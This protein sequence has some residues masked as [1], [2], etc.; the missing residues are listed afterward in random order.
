VHGRTSQGKHKKSARR[1]LDEVK[2]FLAK[3]D[4]HLAEIA[5]ASGAASAAGGESSAKNDKAAAATPASGKKRKP[6]DGG[7]SK[8]SSK[9]KKK[10]AA[11]EDMSSLTIPQREQRALEQLGTYLEEVGGGSPF[12]YLLMCWILCVNYCRCKHSSSR[13]YSPHH[14][15]CILVCMALLDFIPGKR[16]QAADFTCKVTEASTSGKYD[17]AFYNQAGK[18][19][20]SMIA[21]AKSL[22]LVEDDKASSASSKSA[23]NQGVGR[24]KNK[25]E[26]ESEQKKLKKEMDKLLK[27]HEKA[28][29]AL[30]DHRNDHKNDRYPVEDEILIEEEEAEEAAQNGGGAS[31]GVADL[32]H[33]A[34][35]DIDGFPGIP[36]ECTPDLLMCWDFLCKF[37]FDAS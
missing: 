28:T 23:A 3:V 37:V 17:T 9:K 15:T 7:G 34:N 12:I 32:R 22:G 19:L 25:R 4:A 20:R 29:K 33:L 13:L 6:S 11:K 5:E 10:K 35:P 36:V 27:G 31:A 18:R 26:L 8:E 30:D 24:P 16:K 1:N 21:V 14:D 2:T